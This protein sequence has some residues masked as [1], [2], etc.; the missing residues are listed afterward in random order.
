MLVAMHAIHKM[1]L[2]IES[3]LNVLL[4]W[5]IL[6]FSVHSVKVC[7]SFFFCRYISDQ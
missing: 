6:E 2:F 7:I 5:V 3:F 1:L 4:A